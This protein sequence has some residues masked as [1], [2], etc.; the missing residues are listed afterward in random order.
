VICTTH[1]HRVRPFDPEAR[2]PR[3]DQAK[4]QMLC[5]QSTWESTTPHMVY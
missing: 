4:N 1:N 5:T 3:V 2:V